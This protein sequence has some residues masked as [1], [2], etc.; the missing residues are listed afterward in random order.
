MNNLINEISN[1]IQ[2]NPDF[3]TSEN[4]NLMFDQ[5]IKFN[6]QIKGLTEKNIK[7]INND[8]N[9]IIKKIKNYKNKYEKYINEIE[10][11]NSINDIF[12]KDF[13][14]KEINFKNINSCINLFNIKFSEFIINTPVIYIQK[15]TGKIKC[16]YKDFIY[17]ANNFIYDYHNYAILNIISTLN[18]NVQIYLD[19]VN[20]YVKLENNV[21]KPNSINHIFLYPSPESKQRNNFTNYKFNLNIKNNEEDK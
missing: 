6:K 12:I 17:E 7:D 16:N 18:F 11:I 19:E 10:K 8:L 20:Q 9:D 3:S 5:E 1:K 2:E 14:L 4:S 21:L 15:E 13:S